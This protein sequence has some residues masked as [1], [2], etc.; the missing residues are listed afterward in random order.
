MKEFLVL[1]VIIGCLAVTYATGYYNG[2][3][4]NEKKRAPS[5]GT[6]IVTKEET[7]GSK[8]VVDKDMELLMEALQKSREANDMLKE[9]QAESKIAEDKLAEA[10]KMRQDALETLKKVS[11]KATDAATKLKRAIGEK[12]ESKKLNEETKKMMDEMRKDL[13]ELKKE[14]GKEENRLKF[15]VPAENVG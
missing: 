1:V 13:R 3:S 4:N 7:Q 6:K 12:N 5:P 14:D 9:A 2:Y 15:K 8:N 11:E 10:I